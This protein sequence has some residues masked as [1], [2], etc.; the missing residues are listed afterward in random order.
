VAKIAAR[1]TDSSK[2][3]R[4][5]FITLLLSGYLLVE[6][7]TWILHEP[8]VFIG[9]ARKGEVVVFYFEPLAT[10]HM[11]ASGSPSG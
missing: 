9:K 2:I 4:F 10:Q 8:E 7:S 1:I 11:K 5:N 6:V 3:V